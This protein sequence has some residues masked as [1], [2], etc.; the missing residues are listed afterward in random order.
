MGSMKTPGVYIV[1]KNAFPNSI[2]E[3]ATAVPAF[4]GYTEKADNKG[5]TLLNKP[6]RITSMPEFQEYFGSAPKPMFTIEKIDA[7]APGVAAFELAGKRYLLTQERSR[8]ILYH[9]MMLFFANGGGPCYVVSVGNYGNE[10]EADKLSVGIDLLEKEQEPTIVVVPEAALFKNQEDYVAVQ[11]G[12]L[13][14]CG[15]KSHRLGSPCP[16]GR[17]H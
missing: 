12:A 11:L 10:I 2:V 4:I 17:V 9:S 14:H 15:V 1:E 6:R 5:K 8:Y 13:A 3:V 16:A 7:G